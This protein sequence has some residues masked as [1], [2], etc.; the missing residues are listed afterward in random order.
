MNGVLVQSK[1]IYRIAKQ[2]NTAVDGGPCED[3]SVSVSIQ[4]VYKMATSATKTSIRIKD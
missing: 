2:E 4:I 1:R 3:V